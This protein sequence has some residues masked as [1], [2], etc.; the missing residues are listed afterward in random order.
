GSTSQ[1]RTRWPTS[2]ISGRSSRHGFCCWRVA[3]SAEPPKS[4][5][6]GGSDDDDPKKE[7]EPRRPR[8]PRDLSC[9]CGKRR[10]QGQGQGI[11]LRDG[12]PAVRGLQGLGDGRQPRQE[13]DLRQYFG[14][15]EAS[16]VLPRAGDGAQGRQRGVP[17]AARVA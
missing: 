16:R 15:G 14:R 1:R 11:L 7:G 4:N 8:G 13:G 5:P 6:Y 17:V 10:G 12:P 9:A 3:E 2:A